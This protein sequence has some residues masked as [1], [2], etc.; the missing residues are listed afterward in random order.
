MQAQQDR[1]GTQTHTQHDELLQQVIRGLH[2][3]CVILRIMLYIKCVLSQMQQ[4]K[5]ELDA[6][7]QEKN[8]FRS[9]LQENVQMVR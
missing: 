4:L 8:Q 9:D 5:E 1:S 6:V 7:T 3:L 2:T